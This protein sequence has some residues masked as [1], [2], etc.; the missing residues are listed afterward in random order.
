[1]KHGRIDD[2]IKN[3]ESQTLEFKKNFDQA[4]QAR[5]KVIAK[6]KELNCIKREGSDKTGRWV[7]I[8]KK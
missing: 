4:A 7:I 8:N 3:G 5:N 2:I 6:L 1:M